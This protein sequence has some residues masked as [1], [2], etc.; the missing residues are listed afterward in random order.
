MTV[1]LKNAK[2][3]QNTTSTG[4][5]CHKLLRMTTEYGGERYKTN[6]WWRLLSNWI[7]HPNEKSTGGGEDE[8]LIAAYAIG[9]P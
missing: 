2:K 6:H 1:K 9:K 3:R 5:I 8:Q 4:Q 7:G